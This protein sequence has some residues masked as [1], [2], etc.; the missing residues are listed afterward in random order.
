MT[1]Q[2]VYLDLLSKTSSLKIKKTNKLT[3]LSSICFSLIINYLK[4]NENDI[5]FLNSHLKEFKE[6][7]CDYNPH[8]IVKQGS[9]LKQL[10]V[11]LN[12]F[13][14]ENIS[15][16]KKITK[17]TLLASKH[18]SNYKDY[19]AY[20]K[21]ITSKCSDENMI[22]DFLK[23]FHIQYKLPEVYFNKAS[24][25][26][27]EIGLLDTP[28]LSLKCKNYLSSFFDISNENKKIYNYLISL[29]RE[30]NISCDEINQRINSLND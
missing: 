12:S 13:G 30:N 11:V 9:Y 24:S 21:E 23:D 4:P 27:N 25:Y 19:E 14:E 26:F 28:I 3:S 20:K 10:N 5:S 16:L 18:L 29:A 1:Y 22:F 2:E 17:A 7:F 15:S 8:K 6:I